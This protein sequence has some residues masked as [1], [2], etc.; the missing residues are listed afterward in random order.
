MTCW[1]PQPMDTPKRS[2]QVT[3]PTKVTPDTRATR[4]KSPV[5]KVD[6]KRPRIFQKRGPRRKVTMTRKNTTVT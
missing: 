2:L 5:K 6:I 1:P 3:K 4:A